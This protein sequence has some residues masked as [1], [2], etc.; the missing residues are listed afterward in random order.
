MEG[1]LR[2]ALLLLTVSGLVACGKPRVIVGSKSFT[3]SYVLG[4]IG[5]RALERAGVAARHRPG[6]GGTIILWQALRSGSID[7]YPD[8]TGTIAEQILH[9]PGPLSLRQMRDS[10]A[11]LGIGVM[12]PMGFE[13]T[14]ALV[15]RREEAEALGISTVSDLRAH[16]E[17][18]IGLTH[19]FL[20][21]RDGWGPLSAHYGLAMESVRGLDH[22]L[23]YAALARGELDVMDAYS[24]DAKLQA[25]DLVALADDEGF[26]PEYEAVFLY[27]LALP[28]PARRAL[29]ELAGTLGEEDMIRLNAA[30][31]ERGDYAAA[32]ALYFGA[33]RPA[34]DGWPVVAGRI[35]GWTLRHLQLVALSLALAVLL[36]IPLGIRGARPGWFSQL[37]LASVGVIYTIPS[38]AL[39]AVLV[40]VPFLGIETRTAILALFLY[41]LLPIVRNTASGLR[42]IPL[43]IRESAMALGLE[44]RAQLRKVYLPM[45]APTILAGV[46]TSA[47]IN[48]GTATLAALIGAGGLGEPILSGISL[49]DGGVILQGAIPAALLALGVQGLFDALERRVVSRGLRL[50]EERA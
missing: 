32:A 36:G 14:Y 42:S 4:E 40:A 30:A 8:Y 2:L 19:E 11:L 12:D 48:V 38:L 10:L 1:K 29:E 3:E 13:N 49:N 44:P 50:G 43:E 17:L 6:M 39:L 24:T 34:A 45:A 15:M 9:V 27:R 41:S 28:E 33:S 35:L 18:R 22:A 20:E 23:A 37:L 47:V 16:P 21:R 5:A 31:E 46:K 25:L 7:V 26:F